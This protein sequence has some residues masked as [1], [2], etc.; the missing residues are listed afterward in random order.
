MKEIILSDGRKTQVDDED[1]DF[2]N[3]WAWQSNGKYVVRQTASNGSFYMGHEIL[4]R[5]GFIINGLVDHKDRDPLNNQKG[6]LRDA[7]RSQNGA[8]SKLQSNNTSG[9]RGVGF[10][11][12][13]QKWTAEITVRGTHIR[14]GCF[15]D[16]VEAAKAYDKAAKRYFGDFATLNFK[17]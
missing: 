8:N 4:K 13:L 7:T 5:H 9:Y 14:L 15:H 6:N 17:E 16:P 11:R 3:Q 10:H 2:L 12:K 1:Y